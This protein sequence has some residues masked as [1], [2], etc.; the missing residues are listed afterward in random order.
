MKTLLGTEASVTQWIRDLAGTTQ[1][2]AAQ[3]VGE[4]DRNHHRHDAQWHHF[5]DKSLR[6]QVHI[7]D[8]NRYDQRHTGAD[9]SPRN[10]QG[11]V[12]IVLSKRLLLHVDL[13]RVLRRDYRPGHAEP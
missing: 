12:D 9:C 2:Y 7:D 4:R 10:R 8:C 11:P 5:F 3:P 6:H 1:T 13:S